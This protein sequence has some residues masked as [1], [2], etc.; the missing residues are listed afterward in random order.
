M[1]GEPRVQSAAQDAARVPAVSQTGQPASAGTQT[2]G[3]RGTGA[4]GAGEPHS[5]EHHASVPHAG[6]P[7]A[8]VPDAAVVVVNY[9][10][11][12]LVERCLRSVAAGS[13]GLDLEV[14]VV[15]NDSRDG[16]VERLRSALPAAAVVAMSE[17]GG[18]ATG[19]NAGFR[20]S[21]A[22]LVILLNPDTEVRA[23]ALGALIGLLREHP[24]TGVVAPLLEDAEGQP[25]SNGYRRFPGLL[26]LA[27]DLCLPFGYAFAYAPRL[28]PYA[29]SPAALRAGVQPVHVCGAA[30]AIRREAYEQAG[31]FDEGFFLY[32][33]ETEWQRRVAR[34]GWAVEL[35]PA[36]RVCHLV[37]GGGEEALAPSPHFVAGALR[38]LRMQRVPTILARAVFALA[39]ALSWATLRLIACVPAKRAQ[40][41]R[42]AR[43][44]GALLRVALGA[45][46]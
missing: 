45:R 22:P 15:D 6:V 21:R 17:N 7:H 25:A 13:G 2:D 16:S 10:S 14:V 35:E 44:Y 4:P 24:R 23:G 39:L 18:F 37:R 29:I 3:T 43:A 5:G 27:L 8:G 26:T 41:R 31:Q 12:E 30:L 42:Q 32:L 34:A 46:P 9:R 36:A 40:A 38:Y 19:V 11:A 20:H 33:E 1:P 28:H